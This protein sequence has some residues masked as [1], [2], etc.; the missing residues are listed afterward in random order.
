MTE[1]EMKKLTRADLLEMLVEQSAELAAVKAKLTEVEEALRKKELAIEQS[2]SIAEAALQLNS[3]FEAAEASCAQYKENI[4]LLS[5]RQSAAC[6]KLEQESREKAQ[7]MLE[8]TAARCEKMES[9]TKILCA[10]MT[11]KAKAESDSYWLKVVDKLDAYYD[12]HVGLRELLSVVTPI[13][14]QR[15]KK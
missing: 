5:E 3:V 1:K 8:E 14:Q 15:E 11:E 9:E 4:R 10:E 6:A 12:E 2:G 7:S 13:Y